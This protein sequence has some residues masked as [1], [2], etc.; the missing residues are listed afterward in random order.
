MKTRILGAALVLVTAGF[1][2]GC[3]RT[4][5][6]RSASAARNEPSNTRNVQ[7]TDPNEVAVQSAQTGEEGQQTDI[8]TMQDLATEP[9]EYGTDDTS[10][11]FGGSGTAGMSSDSE[12]W[13]I[14]GGGD[15][16]M[17]HGGMMHGG[18]HG[19]AG[20]MHGGG[21]MHG[22]MK[23]DAGMMHGGGM[24]GDAGADAGTGKLKIKVKTK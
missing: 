21:T 8:N 19:D 6:D 23:G 15:A 16:G 17:G 1:G 3:Q 2:F 9:S 12:E 5:D 20:K 14:G 11:S 22:D 10:E 4:Y 13:G 18:M 7:I 24:H